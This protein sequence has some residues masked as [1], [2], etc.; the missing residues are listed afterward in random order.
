[1]RNGLVTFSQMNTVCAAGTGTFIEEQAEKLGVPLRDVSARAEGVQAPLVSDRCTVFMERDI[2]RFL[3]QNYTVNEML[4]ASLFAI[5][6]NYLLKVAVEGNIGHNICFQ[7]ATAKIKALVSAFEQRLKK[8]ITVSKYC[9]L[10]GALGVALI[11]AENKLASHKTSFRGIGLYK[12]KIPIR[13]EYCQL[14]ANNCR[15]CIATIKKKRCSLRLF[16]WP[17]L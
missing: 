5:R 12:E 2:N 13:T 1:M 16:M 11:L 4:A 15:L 6:E 7:G 17:G 9:H 8:P 14:C 3:N 10:T